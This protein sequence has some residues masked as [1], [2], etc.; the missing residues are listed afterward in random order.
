MNPNNMTVKE[1]TEESLHEHI[2]AHELDILV[3]KTREMNKKRDRRL[4]KLNQTLSEIESILGQ[5]S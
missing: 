1:A 4:E 3:S 5:P 2:T